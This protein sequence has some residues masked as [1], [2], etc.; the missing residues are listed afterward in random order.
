M[1]TIDQKNAVK[2][3]CIGGCIYWIVICLSIFTDLVT[4]ANAKS[5]VFGMALVLSTFI[6]VAFYSMIIWTM[7]RRIDGQNVPQSWSWPD[8]IIGFSP[9][10]FIVFWAVAIIREIANG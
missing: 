8:V 2:A 5:G 9:V 4:R 1:V 10:P 3:A 6:G 7:F